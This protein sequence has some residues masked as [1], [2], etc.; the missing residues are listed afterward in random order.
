MNG[1]LLQVPDISSTEVKLCV[2]FES[3]NKIVVLA[4]RYGDPKKLLAYF[5]NTT[6]CTTAPA[7]G[8]Y[9][10]AVFSQTSGNV[11]KP[12]TTPPT[13]FYEIMTI[14]EYHFIVKA[15]MLFTCLAIDL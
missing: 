4:H 1:T 14:S 13:I 5:L 11:L 8:Y 12:T 7:A 10:V 2:S 15:F 3:S 6:N 9:I